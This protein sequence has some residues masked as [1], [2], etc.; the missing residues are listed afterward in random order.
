MMM[1]HP[2]LPFAKSGA[3]PPYR[4][5]QAFRVLHKEQTIQLEARFCRRTR[6]WMEH[7]TGPLLL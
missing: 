4:I 6:T 1:A 2:V 5:K 3:S 7:D